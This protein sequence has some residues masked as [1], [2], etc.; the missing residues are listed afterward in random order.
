MLSAYM[1]FILPLNGMIYENEKLEQ[2]YI[3]NEITY[4]VEQVRNTGCI[5]EDMYMA[6][7][8]RISAMNNSYNIM[9][10]HF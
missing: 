1:M 5:D 3:A 9:I 7:E 2:M 8:K 6:L 4:F 10:T